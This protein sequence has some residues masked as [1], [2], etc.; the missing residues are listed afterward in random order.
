[1]ILNLVG[2]IDDS[3]KTKALEWVMK[4]ELQDFIW[5]LSSISNNN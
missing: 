5:G 4:C 1:M 3:L 2:N